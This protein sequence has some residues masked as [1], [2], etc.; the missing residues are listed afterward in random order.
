MP[1]SSRGGQRSPQRWSREASQSVPLADEAAIG[2]QPGSVAAGLC[3]LAGAEEG[4]AEGLVDS[5]RHRRGRC[6]QADARFMNAGRRPRARGR[7]GEVDRVGGGISGS[8]VGA[9]GSRFGGLG[10]P[11]ARQDTYTPVSFGLRVELHKE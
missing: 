6:S 8:S 11:P 2:G 1:R 10:F 5:D 4:E 9:V 3:R 7:P